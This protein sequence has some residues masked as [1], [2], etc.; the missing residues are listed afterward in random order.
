MDRDRHS[1]GCVR[2]RAGP[3]NVLRGR[4]RGADVR[5]AHSATRPEECARRPTRSG[6]YVAT[7]TGQTYPRIQVVKTADLM[8]GRRPKMP[9]AILPYLKAKPRDPGQLT[10]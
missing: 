6:N 10:L 5:S 7:L 2:G 8:A 3:K 4:S 1:G 9:T